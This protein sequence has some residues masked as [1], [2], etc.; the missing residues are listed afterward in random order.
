MG[1]Y[2]MKDFYPQTVPTLTPYHAICWSNFLPLTSSHRQQ[3]QLD[4]HRDDGRAVVLQ[5]AGRG[6]LGRPRG[7]ARRG[8]PQEDHPM[9]QD[10]SQ[11]IKKWWFYCI[12]MSM[13]Q[14]SLH[15]IWVF[16]C[17]YLHLTFS[18]IYSSFVQV[19]QRQ[20]WSKT[21][22][23]YLEDANSNFFHSHSSIRCI[24]TCCS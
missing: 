6:P 16:V 9:R 4:I 14:Q 17:L 15:G 1:I 10:A 19:R 21:L 13:V 8:A 5:H 7:G 3:R 11:V 20:R 18:G 12:H 23:K 24:I 22:A 2:Q